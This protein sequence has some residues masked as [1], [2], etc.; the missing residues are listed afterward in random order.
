MRTT[1]W[2]IKDDKY[3]K[4]LFKEGFYQSLDGLGVEK[5]LLDLSLQRC[6]TG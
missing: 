4:E 2:K 6:K 1:I 3:L 5:F